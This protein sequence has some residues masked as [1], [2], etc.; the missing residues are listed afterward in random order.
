[1][2]ITRLELHGFKSFP[3]R[4]V[5]HFGDGISCVVGP[6]GSGKSNV[7]DAL[8]W[9][10][11]EQSARSLRGSEMTDVIFAG[12]ADR[13]PVGYAEVALTLKASSDTPF[14]GEYAQLHELQVGRRLHRTG[15]SEYFVNQS[16]VR[17][18]DVVELLLDSGIGNNLYSFIEQGQVDKMI[19]ASP[20]ERRS[21]IDEAA[22]IARYK[23][24]RDEAQQRLVNTSGQ[25]DRAADVL[26]EMT[27]RL[28]SLEQQVLV[29]A[30]FRRLRAQVRQ[31]ELRL[32]LVKHHALAQDRRALR[33]QLDEAKGKEDSTRREVLRREED[34]IE[35]REELATAEAV[36]A[37]RRD[38]VA[39]LDGR[40]RE[41]D[42]AAV[43]HDRRRAE[44]D[45][46]VERGRAE[47]E[48]QTAA[49]RAA[50]ADVLRARE[51]AAA[52]RVR[53]EELSTSMGEA[54][55]ATAALGERVAERRDAVATAEGELSTA[56]D[57][58]AAAEA[59][60]A[61]ADAS[62]RERDAGLATA[63]VRLDAARARVVE[64]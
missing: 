42:A 1:M 19:T 23:A 15:A 48:R 37:T 2:R 63:C 53:L 17:R 20:A 29:A 33:R 57:G 45:A 61:V 6:N 14:P 46:E 24:R 35:R 10:V 26:D 4:T 22:G 34:L 54:E 64:L 43:L 27:R 41:L 30:R 21:L 8:K 13:K 50:E 40:I 56:G 49:V 5:F 7:V 44:L 51:D 36:A 62:A 9:C 38:E 18:R 60:A 32:A 25:L 39:E 59:R 28:R 16:R 55:R 52:Q 3:D 47:V 12:S 58:R 31:G 11:G